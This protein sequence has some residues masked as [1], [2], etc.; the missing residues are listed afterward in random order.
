MDKEEFESLTK[1]CPSILCEH[2][3]DPI[4]D[5]EINDEMVCVIHTH[6]G[7]I[8]YHEPCFNKAYQRRP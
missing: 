5:E 4:S 8:Y 3:Y 7:L 6:D 1:T 2:C